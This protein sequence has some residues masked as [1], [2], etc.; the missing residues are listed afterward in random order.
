ME[1][2]KTLERLFY[3]GLIDI[4]RLTNLTNALLSSDHKIVMIAMQSIDK[5]A[6]RL[7]KNI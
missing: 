6:K 7:S 4:D 1:Y 2:S 3:A 5:K